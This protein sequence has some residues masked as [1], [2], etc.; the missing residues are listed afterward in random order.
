MGYYSPVLKRS[1]RA[2]S[3]KGWPR[4]LS[5]SFGDV[6]AH[7]RVLGPVV[8]KIDSAI[9]WINHYP[10]DNAIDFPNTYPLDSDLSKTTGARMSTFREFN[11]A[12]GFR[13]E[14]WSATLRP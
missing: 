12:P 1:L 2:K 8:R 10:L 6:T 9:Q 11:S 3:G 13:T 7:S 5:G 4:A 14:F